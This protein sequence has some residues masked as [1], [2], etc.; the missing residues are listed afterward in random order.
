MQT[1][2][3]THDISLGTQRER[4][5]MHQYLACQQ[6][7]RTSLSEY[8]DSPEHR[9]RCMADDVPC[10]ICRQ[11]REE[12]FEPVEE[13]QEYINAIKFIG[14]ALIHQARKRVTRA[15]KIPGG[16]C[17][18]TYASPALAYCSL[19]L[20]ALCTLCFPSTPIVAP[21]IA[22]ALTAVC[23]KQPLPYSLIALQP[24]RYDSSKPCFR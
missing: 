3:A 2:P 15:C 23:R 14:E 17:G 18:G 5:E 16:P 11:V 19:H 4:Q 9:R 21:V 20:R 7:F 1:L 8:L 22:S 13:D 24:S 6:C 12:P 10:D